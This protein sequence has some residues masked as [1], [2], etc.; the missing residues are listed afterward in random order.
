M[1]E[2]NIKADWQQYYKDHLITIDEAVDKLADG[3]VVFVGQATI[4][5][6]EFWD[7]VHEK[8]EQFKDLTIWSNV[9]NGPVNMIFDH[10]IKGHITLKSIYQLPM[11]R[12]GIDERTVLPLG[13]TYDQYEYSMWENGVNTS[14]L[15]YCPPMPTAG[16]TAAATVPAQ[17]TP[18]LA[19]PELRRNSLSS[20]KPAFFRHPAL[21]RRLLFT[22]Q[23]SIT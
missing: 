16:A 23:T 3:D 8:K 17:T 21:K 10:D 15:R 12:M 20:T 7:K 2:R 4:I 13:S 11:E 18:P 14:A 1:A 19:T 9:Y 5:P 6:L 22:L